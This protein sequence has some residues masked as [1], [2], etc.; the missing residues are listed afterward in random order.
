MSITVRMSVHPT[1]R[2]AIDAAKA[3]LNIDVVYTT[4]YEHVLV[5]A[6]EEDLLQAHAPRSRYLDAVRVALKRDWELRKAHRIFIIHDN[7]SNQEVLTPRLAWCEMLIAVSAPKGRI[8][9]YLGDHEEELAKLVER[10]G[11]RKGIWI[12]RYRLLTT[13]F[14]MLPAIAVRAFRLFYSAN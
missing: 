13:T 7:R 9:E 5:D 10:F 8:E 3:A 1:Q 14:R 2:E 4:S 11:V 12:R 6:V